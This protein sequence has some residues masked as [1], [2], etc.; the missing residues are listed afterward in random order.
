MARRLTRRLRSIDAFRGA[1]LAFMVLTPATGDP[2]TYPFLR[3]AHWDGATASDLILPTF[4]VT[5]GL[6]LA[7]LLR[8]PVRRRTALR[9][10]RRVVLLVVLGWAYNAY[11][12]S[13][14]DLGALRLTGV[15]QLIGVSGFLA[16]A[17]ALAVRRRDG[18]DRPWLVAGVAVALQ[19]VHGI[20]LRALADRCAGV[21]TCSPFHPWDRA[22]LGEAHTYGA[23]VH[24]YDPEGLVVM[25]AATS[26]VLIGWLVGRALAGAAPEGRGAVA[27]RVAGAGAG[28]LAAAWVLDDIDP[29]NKRLL[30]PAFVCLAAGVALL[31]FSTFLVALDVVG[32]RR[33]RPLMTGLTWPLV[34]LGRNALVVYLLE[35][36]LLQTAATVDVG[37]RSMR[38][39][40]LDALPG[41]DT[42]RHLA[43]TVVLLALVGAVT[44]VLHRRRWYV[45][46]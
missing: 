26:L 44:A 43:Y 27:A 2:A 24:A 32:A 6:S 15:L 29:A 13:G 34:A 22:V 38:R 39:V 18:S 1:V 7:F 23:G 45:A 9:L 14:T 8:A 31:A 17:T 25:V 37:D 11:G 16:A 4:L 28:L 30:T 12:T 5:S 10:V 46:L 42:T 21:D 33:E 40:V 41:T 19:V 3:H 36:F 20:G 35:R